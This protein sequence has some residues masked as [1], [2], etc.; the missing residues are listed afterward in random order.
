MSEENYE[1]PSDIEQRIANAHA[2]R[3]VVDAQGRPITART[4]AT[5]N[6]D[7]VLQKV[8]TG[9]KLKAPVFT[10]DSRGRLLSA[11]PPTP[12]EAA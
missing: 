10:Y 5:Y 7:G 12:D 3:P 2:A 1:H 4:I 11:T 9:P 8:E 6:A